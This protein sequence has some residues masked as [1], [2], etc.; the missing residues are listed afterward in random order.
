MVVTLRR[1]GINISLSA[2]LLPILSCSCG[3]WNTAWSSRESVWSRELESAVISRP[4][5][6]TRSFSTPGRGIYELHYYYHLPLSLSAT[7]SMLRTVTCHRA[8]S[9]RGTRSRNLT[10]RCLCVQKGEEAV[11]IIEDI[12]T[13]DI[14]W[15]RGLHK[16]IVAILVQPPFTAIS[17]GR[18]AIRKV[19]WPHIDRVGWDAWIW[20][21]GR[22]I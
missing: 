2:R 17:M 15:Q 13:V 18:H 3:Q 7:V 22:V 1:V 21:L 19:L 6:S 4:A 9:T 5:S 14:C 20:S 8:A 10:K 12:S 16:N 11:I